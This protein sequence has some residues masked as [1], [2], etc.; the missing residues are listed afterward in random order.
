M[1]VARRA[2]NK[3][4]KAKQDRLQ[5]NL[6]S[7]TRHEIF[8]GKLEAIYTR[9]SEA[10]RRYNPPAPVPPKT[11][12]P[13]PSPKGLPFMP[14][15][16]PQ[17][18]VAES[19]TPQTITRTDAQAKKKQRQRIAAAEMEDELK[20]LF[21]LLMGIDSCL[22]RALLS[23]A[24]NQY[25]FLSRALA[26]NVDQHMQIQTIA[27]KW[28]HNAVLINMRNKKTLLTDGFSQKRRYLEKHFW[29]TV[30]TLVN[31][32]QGRLPKSDKAIF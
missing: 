18:R 7:D 24:A 8:I 4:K 9:L 3:T 15:A 6:D 29:P 31:I 12:N 11:Q 32:A 19:K 28:I 16:I 20:N 21:S 10:N 5:E 1:I 27:G 13:A 25:C 23:P 26:G 14:S 2:R 30:N 17:R 22:L